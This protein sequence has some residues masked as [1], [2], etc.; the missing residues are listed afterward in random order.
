MRR[1][2]LE[3]LTSAFGRLKKSQPQLKCHPHTP[4][5]Q[6]TFQNRECVLI[7]R[8]RHYPLRA[9]RFL[10]KGIRKSLRGGIHMAVS[11]QSEGEN[12]QDMGEI[13]SEH[14]RITKYVDSAAYNIGRAPPHP[15][16]KFRSKKIKRYL[17]LYPG[18]TPR[19]IYGIFLVTTQQVE[20]HMNMHRT[21]W[22]QP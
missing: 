10:A 13:N 20:Q 9:P 7:R 17:V 1:V 5:R 11:V 14:I 4:N 19:C 22:E 15:T 6:S 12:W 18:D 8:A 21:A 3:P 16:C 2:V